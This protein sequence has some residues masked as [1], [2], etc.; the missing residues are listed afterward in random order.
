M[1]KNNLVFKHT[2]LETSSDIGDTLSWKIESIKEDNLPIDTSLADYISF[3][4]SNLESQQ[5]QLKAVKQEITQREK[6]IKSQIESIKID[7]GLFLLENGLERLD[8]LICSSVTVS[9]AKECV[10]TTQEV[11]EFVMNISQAE[12]EELLIGLGKAEIVTK[13]VEK[14]SNYIPSKLK[15]NKRKIAL[16]EVE[17]PQDG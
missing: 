2:S 1:S 6:A 15:I 13:T 9:K 5:L 7:G 8:G 17:E 11:K 16:A 4:V 14:T 10:I 12:L 3:S